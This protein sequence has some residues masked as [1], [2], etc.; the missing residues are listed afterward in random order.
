MGRGGVIVIPKDMRK[1]S[2]KVEIISNGTT[3]DVTEYI[4]PGSG[5][6]NKRGT[7]GVSD[8]VF[9]ID[10][11]GGR[12]K[13]I[14]SAGDTVNIYYEY[15]DSAN[16]IRERGLID[17][18]FDNV[19]GSNGYTLYIKGRC[20]PKSSNNEHFADTH[21]TLQF[22]ARNN[23]DCWFGVDGSADS[24]GNIEDGILYNSGMIMQVYDTVTKS[25][26][27]WKD[28]TS[29]QRNTIKAQTGYTSTHTTSYQDRSRLDISS[30][31]AEEGDYDTYIYYNPSD[32][33]WYY[34]IFP[35]SSIINE[36]EHVAQGQNFI[37]LSNYGADTSQEANRIKT[38]GAND[39]DI[40]QVRSAQ[41]TTRQS[42]LWIKDYEETVAELESDQSIQGRANATLN[43]MKEASKV[44]VLTSCALPTLQSG[45]KIYLNLPYID[46]GSGYI[47]AKDF[48]VTFGSDLEFSI[49]LQKRETSFSELFKDRIT[50]NVNVTP[51]NNPNGMRNFV[52]RDFSDSS[53]YTLSGEVQI[54]N[55]TLSL[56]SGQI[57][58]TCTTLA[59]NSD[60]NINKCEIRVKGSGLWA[61]TYRVRNAST[62]DWQTYV[63]GSSTTEVVTFASSG[64]NI[65]LEITLNE[66]DGGERPEFEKVDIGWKN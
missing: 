34:R 19:N 62:S 41:N 37:E 38:R 47:K 29:T 49:N 2:E 58:G 48:T 57:Q 17:G 15:T 18:V 66:T 31:V 44:G 3:R 4:V 39:G 59:I 25:W 21:I 52:V 12:Y 27:T 43:N 51:T 20:C 64:N 1:F 5:T 30:K 56:K 10:N 36:N 22:I 40:V 8:F 53:Q 50:E 63:V 9:E 26:K 24:N 13:G 46:G 16:T 42:A 55:E 7:N 33:K 54:V 60:I 14:F 6:L 28:L 45:E 11:N 23:L 32:G 65:Q 61:C 35:E